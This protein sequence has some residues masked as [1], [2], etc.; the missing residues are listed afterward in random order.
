MSPLSSYTPFE[1]LL[2]FQSLAAAHDFQ[3]SSFAAISELLQTNPFIR[4]DATFDTGRLTPQALEKLYSAL[5]D[6]GLDSGDE[7]TASVKGR[8]E[9][10]PNPKKR[11][12]AAAAV[13]DGTSSRSSMAVPGLVPKLYARYK[14]GIVKEI[15]HDEEKYKEI[16]DE[17]MKLENV[18]EQPSPAPEV[19]AQPD[20]KLPAPSPTSPSQTRPRSMSTANVV[21]SQQPVPPAPLAAA[22][23]SAGQPPPPSVSLPSSQAAAAAAAPTV[24]V[25]QGAAN[26]QSTRNGYQQIHPKTERGRKIQPAPST[27]RA[28]N[29]PIM[30]YQQAAQI[31]NPSFSVAGS[32]PSPSLS[33]PATQLPLTATSPSILAQQQSSQ[34]TASQAPRDTNLQQQH[35]QQQQQQ[36]QPWLPHPTAQSTAYKPQPLSATAPYPNNQVPA[37]P[38]L[39]ALSIPSSVPV[40]Q[41]QQQQIAQ[42]TRPE[43]TIIPTPTTP[44]PTALGG[45][46]KTNGEAASLSKSMDRP[47]LVS[48][49]PWKK[50]DP[51]MIPQRPTTPEPPRPED[52][53]PISEHA[54]SPV[55]HEEAPGRRRGRK[56]SDD[57]SK[58]QQKAAPAASTRRRKVTPAVQDKASAA[59]LPSSAAPSIRSRSRGF[60]VTSRDEGFGTDTTAQSKVKKE[61]PTTPAGFS[62]DG[63]TRGGV[64]RKRPPSGYG[65]PPD[66]E[67][68]PSV[69]GYASQYVTCTRNFSRTCGPIMND[70]ATHKYAS[71]FAKP[72]TDREA[73]GYRNLIYRPQDIKSIKSAIYQGGR[74]VAAATDAGDAAET[75]AT[76]AGVSAI[77]PSKSSGIALK[78]TP[79][80]VPPKA[81]VQSS[82]LETEVIRMFAN[83]V[84]FNPTP[85]QTFG[86][87]FPMTRDSRSREG[88]E[89]SEPEEGGIIND[90][91]EMHDDIE[92]ALSTWRA[93]ERAVDDKGSRSSF[94]SFRRD[95]VSDI[96][97]DGADDS[98][99][100]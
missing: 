62:D 40:N 47:Q 73:P 70:V 31:P 20:D 14:D 7:T 6:E 77:P 57:A 71:I 90:T 51:I 96:N 42:V 78:K 58:A 97:V 79:D 50:L 39:P 93:A 81:I 72:L 24:P 60:S 43:S 32:A 46:A 52:I 98:K 89:R 66:E 49:T 30:P 37:A 34:I 65:L 68:Q 19:E 91:L 95:S 21:T 3:P 36:Q 85:E 48:R 84:M 74:A 23:P 5:V 35:H 16:K 27:T 69:A 92:K 55:P 54:P 22:S 99:T 38:L 86:P 11:K 45:P 15:R 82:Q 59:H 83:A 56:T 61:A 10:P 67:E 13:Q 4:E 25:E 33:A 18:P 94:P 17:I 9:Q 88:S 53:S 29:V 87:A 76:P 1:S 100:A 28:A 63:T 12:V 44:A 2:F 26:T 75:P 8:G 64:K 80:L 41:T